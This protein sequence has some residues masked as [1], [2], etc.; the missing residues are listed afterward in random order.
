MHPKD[1]L[2]IGVDGGKSKT[3]CLVADAQGVIR[4]WGRSGNSD[5]YSVPFDE[6][7]HAIRSCVEEALKR[8]E[9]IPEQVAAACFG[10]AGADWPEDFAQLR[11]ALEEQHLAR[12]LIVKNDAHIAL[13][14]NLRDGAGMVVTA[15][16]HLAAAVRTTRGG[17]WH[18]GWFSVEGCG[19]AETGRK[20]L[21]AVLKAYD[22]RGAPTVLSELILEAL[23][24]A[25][26]LD[27]L[28]ALSQGRFG[29]SELAALTPLV[30]RA[31]EE[32]ADAVAAQLIQ[33]IAADIAAWVLALARRF[34]L[35]HGKA[36]VFICG[37]LVQRECPL[38]R[39]TLLAA[40][41]RQAPGVQITFSARP[42]VLGALA[43]AAEWCGLPADE[44]WRARL[45]EGLKRIGL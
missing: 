17:E 8:A 22:G 14:A 42:T 1:E 27:L 38:L 28:H 26:P 5:K 18:S 43:Y 7:I 20:A 36:P 11:A 23:D 19:G 13:H 30:F 10:L 6:A 35:L 32:Y 45:E 41:H 3:L 21:W 34:D 15:G 33:D 25:H 2:L 29:E 40:V 9:A 4:G 24:M 31:H 37:G 16:T 39:E 44:A 12:H